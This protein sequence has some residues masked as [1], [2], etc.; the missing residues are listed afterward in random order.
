[1]YPSLKMLKKNSLVLNSSK[2]QRTAEVCSHQGLEWA[3][4]CWYRMS[5]LHVEQTVRCRLGYPHSASMLPAHISPAR[6][7]AVYLVSKDPLQVY[8]HSL[9]NKKCDIFWFQ[10]STYVLVITGL[11]IASCSAQR[12]TTLML[13]KKKSLNTKIK[14]TQHYKERKKR[15][16]P[17]QGAILKSLLSYFCLS[18]TTYTGNNTEKQRETLEVH[19]GLRT[20]VK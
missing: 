14:K 20:F 3:G 11:N 8:F 12:T 2:S 10:H 9:H 5:A 1:M 7:P 18:K 4:N 13:F 6:P 19:T 16:K 15:S 17:K